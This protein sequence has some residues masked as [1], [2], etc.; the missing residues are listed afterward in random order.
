MTAYTVCLLFTKYQSHVLL[1]KKEKTKYKGLLNGIGGK[2]LP[3]ESPE[4]AALRKIKDEADIEDVENLTL[5]GSVK[6][7]VD[8]ND[9]ENDVSDG[10]E[11]YFFYGTCKSL[12]FCSQPKGK[13]ELFLLDTEAILRDETGMSLA[14]DLVKYFIRQAIQ[15]YPKIIAKSKSE[16]EIR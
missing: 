10:C 7:P 13:E 8:C 1:Q 4:E 12:M 6:L 16:N 9:S 5:L 15:M 11:L 14:N 3:G 2:I